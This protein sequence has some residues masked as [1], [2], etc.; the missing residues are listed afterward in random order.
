[1]VAEMIE[2]AAEEASRPDTDFWPIGSGHDV[3][4]FVNGCCGDHAYCGIG[5]CCASFVD[6]YGCA[7]DEPSC[8]KTIIHIHISGL[9]DFG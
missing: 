4:C 6:F 8:D 7:V 2:D 1:M 9:Y 5:Y 3:D